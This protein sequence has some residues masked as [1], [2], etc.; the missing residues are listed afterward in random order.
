[1]SPMR[2]AT[3]RALLATTVALALAT[4]PSV[5]LADQGLPLDRAAV[6]RTHVPHLNSASGGGGAA[7]LTAVQSGAKAFF[8]GTGYAVGST[9]TPTT[10]R[11]EAEEH[12]AVDPSNSAKLV[13]AISDFSLREGSN[14][15]KFAVSANNG[16][17]WTESFVPLNES[18]SPVTGDGQTWPFNSDPV[19]AIDRAGR[20]F[21][22]DLYFHDAG[23]DGSNANGLYVSVGS[24]GSLTNE[25]LGFTV[26]STIAVATNPSSTTNISE[27]KEW[28]AVDNSV[29][30]PAA[31]GNVYVC[32]TRFIG[33]S[34]LIVFARS[35][36]HGASW[37]SAPL[38]ISPPAQDGAVQG[39][40]V[41]VGLAGKVYVAYEVFFVGGKRQHLLAKSNDF[42]LSFSTPAAATQLFNEVSFNST[43][44]K[45]SF[46]SL[47]AG[48]NGNVYMVYADQRG[49]SGAEVEFTASTNGG[50]SFT[51]PVI[52]NDSSAGQQF[53]PALT[54][55][56]SGV[57]H[58]SWF[59][60][61]LSPKKTALYDIFATSST[62]GGG[63]FRPN[64]RVTAATVDA[65][66][67]RFI[68]DYAGIAAGGRSAHP[69]WTSGGFNNGSL[70]TATLTLP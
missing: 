42:G 17:H 68:G 33:N 40:Q 1:M 44:R 29:G 5:A 56:S 27:D 4:L 2:R 20:V 31:G 50:T 47:A 32:W 10:T 15:T 62:D 48:P 70:Q 35:T 36:D 37:S 14:T 60:T 12:I 26:A 16:A 34:D 24:V 8:S 6:F 18:G 46:A 63:T 45:N 52:I 21:L 51:A 22:A 66:L 28:I 61:R 38:R 39:C 43:Y 23:F 67:A 59:D 65:G 69:V 53:M 19:V 58:A 57:I 64:A 41:A 3:V 25:N 55:D 7:G 49:K 13:A 11:P 30:A 54:V 9:I